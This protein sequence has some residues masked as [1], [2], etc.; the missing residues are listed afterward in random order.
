MRCNEMYECIERAF[1]DGYVTQAETDAMLAEVVVLRAFYYYVLTCTFGDVPRYFE[2]VTE[3]NRAEIARLPRMSA[4]ETRSIIIEELK[5]WL[6]PPTEEHPERKCALPLERTYDNDAHLVGAAVGLM[7]AGKMAMWNEQWEDA[8]EV[9]GVLEEIYGLGAGVDPQAALAQYPLSDVPFGK[10]YT[11]ES[12]FEI[13]NDAQDYGQ[14]VTGMLAAW[15]M[16]S[17]TS[18]GET[19][20]GRQV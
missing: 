13:S 7:L 3:Q 18:S 17:K 2:R 9:Y 14:Q 11:R 20:D 5:S 6:M 8:V 12:I 4:F 10:K 16:P 1:N 15:C 19:D